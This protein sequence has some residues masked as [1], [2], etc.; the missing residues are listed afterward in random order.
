MPWTFRN[1]IIACL[2]PTKHA[3]M[4]PARKHIRWRIWDYGADGGYFITIRTK[5][6]VPYFRSIRPDLH[7]PDDVGTGH[8]LST[9]KWGACPRPARPSHYTGPELH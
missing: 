6:R 9:G 4:K 3:N 1:E 2:G 5:H 8:A 7:T